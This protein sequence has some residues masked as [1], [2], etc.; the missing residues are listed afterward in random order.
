MTGAF[1]AAR[2][3]S[4]CVDKVSKRVREGLGT[5]PSGLEKGWATFESG[6]EKAWAK[7]QTG[8]EK[9]WARFQSG[10]EEE[11]GGI[12]SGLEKGLGKDEWSSMVGRIRVA[13]WPNKS[14]V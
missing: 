12:S 11:L 10:L 14:R 13:Y 9:G 7:F 3:Y 4:S 6:L 2:R 8:L 5:F 1:P